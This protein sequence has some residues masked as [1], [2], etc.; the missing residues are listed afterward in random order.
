MDWLIFDTQQTQHEDLL[1]F[2]FTEREGCFLFSSSDWC[3]YFAKW[4]CTCPLP[5]FEPT[6]FIDGCSL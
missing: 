3:I 2:I 6:S 5:D 4:K 1:Y